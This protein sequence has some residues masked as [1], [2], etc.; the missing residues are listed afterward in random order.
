VHI[1]QWESLGVH[2]SQWK[3]SLLARVAESTNSFNK[4]CVFDRRRF[5]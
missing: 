4:Y 2:H 5:K 3:H 1:S